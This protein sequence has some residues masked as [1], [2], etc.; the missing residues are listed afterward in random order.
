MA[1]RP[2]P[3]VLQHQNSNLTEELPL[4]TRDVG[5]GLPWAEEVFGGPP[6]VWRI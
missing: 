6:E 3:A 5:P 2:W 4:L 1:M